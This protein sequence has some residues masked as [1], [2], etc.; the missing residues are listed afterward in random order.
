MTKKKTV[1]FALGGL[2]GFN[3]HGVGFFKAT[4]DLCLRPDIISCTSGQIIWAAN[5]LAGDDI[6]AQID[7][8]IEDGN[9][10]EPPFDWVNA[11]WMASTG[12]EG[13]FRPAY[14]ENAINFF[15]PM[16]EFTAREFLNRLFPA[17][18]FVPERSYE[19]FDRVADI[20]NRSDVGVIFN[21]FIPQKGQEC[22][23]MNQVACDLTDLKYGQ[24][25]N[26]SIICPID[27]EGVEAALWLY[28]Y[29]FECQNKGAF[30]Q[31]DGAYHR[32][33]II[34]EL[35]KCSDVIFSVRPQN[36]EWRG[37]MPEND[38]EMKNFTTLL[39]FNASYSGE[40]A[41]VHLINKLLDQG[42]LSEAD[43]R[44]IHFEEIQLDVPIEFT[45]Y[46][47]E[48]S[49]VYQEGYDETYSKINEMLK[50]GQLN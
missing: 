37:P 3:A 22:L 31:L 28:L 29:G 35:C 40:T 11:Y 42:K 27:R 47:V 21:S 20:F 43:Y 32:Q 8:Q 25:H 10:F 30:H 41:K 46:F 39:W 23:H 9:V 33:F 14:M 4:Q 49:A 5:Y 48:R 24:E 16:Q 38:F 7:K 1:A 44:K 6:K 19:E 34:R 17:Q 13:I 18:K 50:N 12:E 36:K 45:Q 26:D 2:G 15:K